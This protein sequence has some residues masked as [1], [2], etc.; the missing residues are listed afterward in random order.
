MEAGTL[1]QNV[2]YYGK[3]VP[4]PEQIVLSAGPLSLIYESGDLR[5][6]RLGQREILR[7]VYVAVR[8][9]NWGTVLPVLSNVQIQ[10]AADSFQISYDVDNRQDQ[11]DFFWRGTIAGDAQGTISFA[12][13]GQVDPRQMSL[14]GAGW[15]A[16]SV[17]YLCESGA[18]SLTYYET[19]GW[20]GVI[21][22]ESGA[23]LPERFRSLPGGVFPLYHVLADVGEFAG[24]EVIPSESSEPLRVEGLVL[25]P[26]DVFSVDSKQDAVSRMQ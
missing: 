12:M 4:P 8:D 24:G 3:D 7:R 14:F 21:E 11:I 16:G 25:Q 6:I 9:R 15:T 17:K 10:Q 5:Y 18:A 26:G 1:P 23:P 19:S 2:L 22:L 20:R 13:E